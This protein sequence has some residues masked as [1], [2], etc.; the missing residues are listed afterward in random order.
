MTRLPRTSLKKA[1]FQARRSSVWLC[2]FA[3]G[4]TASLAGAALGQG[5]KPAAQRYTPEEARR[6]VRLMNDIYLSGVL[7]AHKMYVLDRGTAAAVTWGKQVIGQMN[8]K[9]WPEAHIFSN[10]DRALNPDNRPQDE[11]ERTAVQAFQGGKSELERTDGDQLRYAA[12]IRITKQTCLMCH[13]H[14]KV[15]DLLGGV[16]YR[17]FL[18]PTTGK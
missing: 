6:T 13:V 16:S 18:R 12:P 7:T 8:G 4:V 5:Q 14:N 15:G 1:G 9:G 3:L 11:F 10:G 17:A 2:C